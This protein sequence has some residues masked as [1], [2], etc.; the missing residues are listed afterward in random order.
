MVRPNWAVNTLAQICFFEIILQ[1]VPIKIILDYFEEIDNLILKCVWT[2][3]E[4]KM[5]K[6]FFLKKNHT[7]FLKFTMKIQE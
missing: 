4:S 1:K 5:A 6:T 2:C 7:C 3:K